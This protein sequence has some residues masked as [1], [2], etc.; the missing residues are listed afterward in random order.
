MVTS[1]E[2]ILVLDF[3]GQYNQLIAR[4]VRELGVYCEV[5]PYRLPV[6]EIKAKNPVGI[7]FTGGPS[8]VYDENSPHIAPEVFSL[9]IPV[10]GLCYGTQLMAQTLGGHV[11]SP[12]SREYGRTLT[13]FDTSCPLFAGLPQQG[14]TW[15]S[16]TDYIDVL[17]EGFV[18]AASTQATPYAAMHDPARRLYGIQFHPEVGHTEHGSEML[19]RFVFDVCGAK[20]DWSMQDY[21]QIAIEEIRRQVGDG[22]VLLALS[23]GVDSSVVAAL[24]SKAIG[25]QLTCIFVDHGLM[26]KN[27]GDEVEAAFG[28]REL[29]FIRV[30]AGERF[31]AR[32]A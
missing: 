29:H 5:H 8:S 15:M 6:A 27:E 3:G 7:I 30:N 32:L 12:D 28:G 20:G 4:R 23:G 26:R 31:L 19:R 22:K 1:N 10:L 9:G 11:T 2:M 17:P 13:Q 18:G 21:A 24:L 14:Q 16:H 25:S